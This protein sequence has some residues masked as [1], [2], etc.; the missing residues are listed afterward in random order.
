MVELVDTLVLGTSVAR[1]GGSSPLPGTIY[2]SKVGLF[3]AILSPLNQSPM[4]YAIDTHCHLDYIPKGERGEAIDRAV[5]ANVKKMITVACNLEQ[6]EQ[7]LP[8]A[9]QYDFIWTTAGIHPTDLTDNLERDLKKVYEY[10]KS[11]KKVVAIGEI[12]LDYYHDRFPHDDQIAFLKGQLDI[13]NQLKKP[14]IL[15]CRAGKFAGENSEVFPDMLNILKE[16]KTTNAVMHCFSGSYD[17]A[18]QFLDLGLMLSFTGITTYE[19]NEELRRIIKDMP[20]DRM[21][22]ETDAP[23]LPPKKHRGEKNEPAYVIEVVKT[24]A[25]VREME[26]DE[27][28]EITSRNAE[29][30]FR[31]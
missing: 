17:E 23:F 14:A 22:V 24:I 3:F 6:V 13:A 26:V 9:D 2:H 31:I 12:G 8:L 5:K 20:L 11:G 7:C 28:L 4:S 1:R 16:T 18:F 10:V 27:I 25:E 30:F 29:H 21:M 15:H 19:R